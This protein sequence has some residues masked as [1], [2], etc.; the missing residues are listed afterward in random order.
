MKA[1]II[2]SLLKDFSLPRNK[3]IK[4]RLVSAS[5]LE[6]IC[7]LIFTAAEV[8]VLIAGIHMK[9]CVA[10]EFCL[11]VLRAH[12]TW[13]PLTLHRVCPLDRCDLV[14]FIDTIITEHVILAKEL[15]VSRLFLY[16]LALE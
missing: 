11:A 4:L 1:N 13:H 15:G 2:A 12:V 6:W 7:I 3:P 16:S 14:L 5:L 9:L 8:L 10:T